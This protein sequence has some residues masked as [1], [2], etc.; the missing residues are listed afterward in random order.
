M[1]KERRSEVLIVERCVGKN[2][3]K[4]PM[5]CHN[6]FNVQRAKIGGEVLVHHFE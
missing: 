1:K 6:Y 4:N 5:N 2:L 3:I